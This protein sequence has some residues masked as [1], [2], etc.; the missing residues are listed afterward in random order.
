[1]TEPL[2][3]DEV[4]DLIRQRGG[5]ASRAGRMVLE[6]LTTAA[7]EH[8]TAEEVAEDVWRRSP[9]IH[10]ATIYRNLE[11]LESLGV[12]YHTHLGHGP[13]Q[14]HLMARAHPH[15]TCEHCGRVVQAPNDAFDSLRADLLES[16]GF[17]VDLRHF[18]LTGTCAAC[19]EELGGS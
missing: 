8:L 6:S 15:L 11:R 19:A 1:V 3:V 14:W 7:G 9:D 4:L 13:A 16:T 2:S 10:Q 12:A 18:A 5:R 17:R